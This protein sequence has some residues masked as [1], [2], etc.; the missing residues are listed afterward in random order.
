MVSECFRIFQNVSEISDEL[1]FLFWENQAPKPFSV[2]LGTGLYAE[3]PQ[4]MLENFLGARKGAQKSKRFL[5][6]NNCN[7]V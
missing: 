6:C 4:S 2:R 5:R 1:T 3:E 7:M